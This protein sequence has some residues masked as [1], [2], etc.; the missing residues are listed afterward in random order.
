VTG[1]R[2]AQ[3]TLIMRHCVN[4][5]L[6]SFFGGLM[7][8]SFFVAKAA[9]VDASKTRALASA[10]SST[11]T[12]P[13]DPPRPKSMTDYNYSNG[14]VGSNT[15][16]VSAELAGD[17]DETRLPLLPPT[18]KSSEI[19]LEVETDL[20]EALIDETYENSEIK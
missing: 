13:L 4:L 5:V 9:I 3:F 11:N 15:E 12:R 16:G 17:I 1:F 8:S 20:N 19:V 2:I 14:L 18:L 7:L 10:R 6:F